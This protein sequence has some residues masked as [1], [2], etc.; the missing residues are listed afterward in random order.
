MNSTEP[1]FRET[2]LPCPMADLFGRIMKDALAG[3]DAKYSIERDDGHVLDDLGRTYLDPFPEWPEGE[4]QAIVHAKGSVLD[5]GCGA[6]RV[7]LYLREQGYT[8]VGV[9]ISPGAVEVCRSQGLVDTRVMAAEKMRFDPNT[10]DT[11]LLFGNNFGILGNEPKIIKMLKNLH[12]ITTPD[13]IILASSRNPE[14]TDDPA[15]LTYHE[16][17][18]ERQRPVGLVRIRLKYKDEME[19]WWELLLASPED[20]NRLAQ[21][22]GWTLD[23]TFGPQNLYVGLLRKE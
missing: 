5:I 10:F 19:D 21:Q 13:A 6:G 1:F 11:V 20:M 18:R 15:H 23:R 17:N 12:R 14:T 7:M 2:T 22:A 3:E 8:T 4:R 16:W 9:D